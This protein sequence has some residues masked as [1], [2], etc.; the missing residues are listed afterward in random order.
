MNRTPSHAAISILTAGCAVAALLGACSYF[1]LASP[2][3]MSQA[4]V[5]ERNIAGSVSAML[6][7]SGEML[8]GTVSSVDPQNRLIDFTI[9]DPYGS[10][11]AVRMHL[12]ILPQAIVVSQ[13]VLV[14]NGVVV[15]LS[16]PESSALDLI[17][18]GDRVAVF[19]ARQSDSS[20]AIPYIAF[21]DPL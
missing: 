4:I 8:Y 20:L 21:G 9:P 18:P 13:H 12:P 2:Y 10:G 11:G 7:S 14:S 16:S 3:S 6:S 19:A 5:R 1:V 17:E 15:G